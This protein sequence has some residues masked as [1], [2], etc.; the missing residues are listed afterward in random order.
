MSKLQ[1]LTLGCVAL[2]AWLVGLGGCVDSVGTVASLSGQLNQRQTQVDK[3]Q[4]ELEALQELSE[5]Q[6]QQI[7]Q[8]SGG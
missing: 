3:L 1:H 7:D 5:Q 2:A 8:G 4:A 6:R